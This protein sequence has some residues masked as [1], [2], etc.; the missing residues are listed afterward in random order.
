MSV[1]NIRWEEARFKTHSAQPRYAATQADKKCRC[2]FNTALSFFFF[3]H[4]PF[5]SLSLSFQFSFNFHTS[6][7]ASNLVSDVAIIAMAAAKT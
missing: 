4:F 6:I 3:P 7:M 2:T 5:S 1:F